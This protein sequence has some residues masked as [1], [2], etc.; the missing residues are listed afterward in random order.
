MLPRKRFYKILGFAVAA[1]VIGLLA[2]FLI[3]PSPRERYKRAYSTINI[4]DSKQSMITAFGQ[5]S[6]ITDCYSY[7]HTERDETL[8]AKCVEEY[9]YKAA[10]EEWVFVLDR[11]GV[12]IAKGHDVSY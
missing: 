12:V 7:Q 8:R 6:E 5:P 1:L 10:L 2:V 4:G 3:R 9:W 11:N